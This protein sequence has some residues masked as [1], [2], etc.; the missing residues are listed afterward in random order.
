MMNDFAQII[1]P[2]AE[3]LLGEPNRAMSSDHE[4]RYGAR[5]SLAIDLRKGTWYDF[6][7]E[8][9]G[10]AL[11]LVTR[12]TKL[13][14]PDRLDWLK[15]HGFMAETIQSNGYQQ[16]RSSIIATYD[17]VDEGGGLLF[18]VVRYEPKDF[19]QRRK[20][21]P[22]DAPDDIKG[23][24]VWSTKG[25]KPVPYRLPDLIDNDDRVVVIVEGEKD[26][27]R[28]WKLGIPATCN[29]GGAGKWSDQLSDYFHEADVVI[30]PDY[31]PQKRH[32]KTKEPMVHPDGRPVLP[33]QDHAQAVAQ[34]LAGV[35]K[36]VRVLELWRSWPD[37]PLKGD[38]SDWIRN[39]G[40]AE[41]LYELIEG[42]PDWSP[43]QDCLAM[44]DVSAWDGKPVPARDWAVMDRIVRRAVTLLSGE[45]GVGKSILILQL[46]CAH[47]LAGDWFGRLPEPGAVMYLNAEDDERELHFRL[48]AIVSH[49]GTT[50]A[51][52]KDLHLVPLAGEDALLGVP[53]RTGIIRPTPLFD[54]L[55]TTAEKIKPVLIALDT[56]ADM[57]GGNENDRSQVRQ[58]IS[59]LR[60]LAITGNAAVLL[61]SHPSLSGINSDS[62]LSG[63]TGWH[64]S[65]RSRL[66]FKAS[67]TEGGVSRDLRELE[68]KKNNYG[69]SGEVV[70][71]LWRNGVFVPVAAPSAPEQAAADQRTED[72]F[73][74]LL[75]RFSHE[76]RKVSDKTGTNY[77]PAKFADEPE[78]KAAK[79]SKQ[80]LADAMRRLFTAERIRVQEDGPPSH[81]RS[82]L[83][84][85]GGVS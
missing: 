65:V 38:V 66:F 17:Y 9:G 7:T 22:D 34:A 33:G 23:G 82:R 6:E 51:A 75:A 13:T 52:L 73:M 20:P 63:S 45:G 61:C 1:G 26:V 2:L 42:T 37:M 53:D 85:V 84:I 44:L 36:R 29:A 43:A 60:R 27:D 41:K 64:N 80:T 58:F 25:I 57:F 39:G 70:R 35:A 10:G 31:D 14:G 74:G 67:A 78:A 28:L 79:C 3:M 32:P 77:A 12:E 62:G 30:I 68:V 24:W 50:F 4:L 55:M 69:P 83:V 56:A 72:V 21:R 40:T 48:A 59:L 19:R 8:E 15:S 54:R 81:R 11:D 5:G 76:G 46:A 71:M 16:P 18:Q 47:V 49:L